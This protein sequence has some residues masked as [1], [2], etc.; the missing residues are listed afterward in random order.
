MTKKELRE[1]IVLDVKS[2]LKAG[3]MVTTVKAT[4]RKVKHP[5]TG[6]QKMSFFQKDPP[7]QI[8]SSWGLLNGR[9]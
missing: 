3:G 1:S 5:A 4:K 7:K 2:F 8:Q 9:F 6:S